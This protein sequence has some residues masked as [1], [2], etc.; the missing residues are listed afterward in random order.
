MYLGFANLTSIEQVMPAGSHQWRIS[1]EITV[2]S[3]AKKR[4]ISEYLR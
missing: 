2:Q 3:S 1:D 4:A